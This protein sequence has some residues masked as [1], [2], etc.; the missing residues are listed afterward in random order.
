[1][2]KIE[3]QGYL[4]TLVGATLWGVSAVVSKSLF[5]LG[6]RPGELVMVRLTLSA[7]ILLVL[8]LFSAREHLILSWKDAPYFLIF[9][10]IA[11]TGMQFT[12]FFTISK[13]QTG[14]AVLMQ[15]LSVFWVSLYAFLFQKEPLSFPKALALLFSLLGCYLIVGGYQLDLLKLNRD[16][17]VSGL[18][19]SLFFAFY[20]LYGEKGLKRFDPW[21]LLLYGFGGSALVTWIFYSPLDLLRENHPPAF[22]F[23]FFYIA[24]F[25]TL[26][27]FGFYFKGVERIRA[28]RAGITSTWE[29]VVAGVTAYLVLG[30][31]LHPLQILGGLSVIGAITLLQ[32]AKGKSHAST[33]ME[34][35]RKRESFV[36]PR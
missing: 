35:R 1:M 31:S 2:K 33:P 5:Q 32:V 4:F 7:L 6:L 27:P 12:Y 21:V 14:P 20:S 8:L 22:W 17:I 36:P 25:S 23:A 9:G 19:G 11:V 28:T 29:P 15:Y 3:I 34:L 16:G 10:C 18:L 26:I 24:V 13:I 30:E